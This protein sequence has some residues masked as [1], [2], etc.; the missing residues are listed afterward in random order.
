MT[1]NDLLRQLNSISHQLSSGEIPVSFGDDIDVE[2]NLITEGDPYVEIKAINPKTLEH[3]D[4]I[5]CET[6]NYYATHD[7]DMD[8]EEFY[9]KVLDIFY[10]SD[11]VYRS[12]NR[13]E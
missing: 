1:L 3:L 5:M 6:S 8:L 4:T 9:K 7:V 11:R 10:E 2:I 13:A 12:I